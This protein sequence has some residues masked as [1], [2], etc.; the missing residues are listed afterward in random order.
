MSQ[1]AFAEDAVELAA[2]HDKVGFGLANGAME[3][4]IGMSRELARQEPRPGRVASAQA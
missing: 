3:Q 1:K 2:A 4:V